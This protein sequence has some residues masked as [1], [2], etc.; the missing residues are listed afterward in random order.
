MSRKKRP[1]IAPQLTVYGPAA[2]MTRNSTQTHHPDG[3][4]GVKS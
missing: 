3:T 4:G 2:T 1:Y